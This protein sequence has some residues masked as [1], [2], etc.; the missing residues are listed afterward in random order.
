MDAG[1]IMLEILS[2]DKTVFRGEVTR[3]YIPGKKAP[4]V[5]LYNHAPIMSVLDKGFVEWDSEAGR[6]RI[7]VD[8]G[9]LETRNNYV[10]IC[11]DTVK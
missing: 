10:T 9:F 4:F 7:L 1:N 11:I 6:E 5:I 8:G 2:P 3:I